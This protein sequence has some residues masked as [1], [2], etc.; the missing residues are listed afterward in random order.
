MKSHPV[1][2]LSINHYYYI[3]IIIITCISNS[4]RGRFDRKRRVTARYLRSKVFF[5]K[6]ARPSRKACSQALTSHVTKVM[7]IPPRWP[8]KVWLKLPQKLSFLKC[9]FLDLPR[10]RPWQKSFSKPLTCP[11]A[12]PSAA[13]VPGWSEDGCTHAQGGKAT[14]CWRWGNTWTTL[15]RGART[16][17][18]RELKHRRYYF[19]IIY[20][21][22]VQHEREKTSSL[23]RDFLSNMSTHAHWLQCRNSDFRSTSV[24][25]NRLCLGSPHRGRVF[26]K[27]GGTTLCRLPKGWSKKQCLR[28][29]ISGTRNI[30]M[31]G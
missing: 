6:R 30:F 26:T 5:Q 1:D 16:A 29:S 28:F 18:I 11:S 24:N 12:S 25:Q 14:M 3:I 22:K 15:L 19:R 20:C 27:V 10:N 9:F 17:V 7:S 21:L 8:W 2:I 31:P 23:V 4:T 13:S